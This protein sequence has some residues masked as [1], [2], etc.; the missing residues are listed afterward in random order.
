MPLARS[1]SSPGRLG[2]ALASLTAALL[3]CAAATP[4]ARVVDAAIIQRTAEGAQV[5]FTIQAEAPG[6]S[7]EI[8]LAR[9]HS[10][11]AV[12]GRQVHQGL[13]SAEAAIAPNGQATI[14]LPVAFSWSDV[15]L[16]AAPQAPLTLSYSLRARVQYVPTD[17]LGRALFATALRRPTVEVVDAGALAL[18]RPGVEG[19]EDVEKQNAAGRGQ[20][21]AAQGG[22][23]GAS[24]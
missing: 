2:L 21:P 23:G 24:R 16:G 6:A 8:R 15:G 4:H 22:D 12:E 19:V 14:L 20:Q 18:G 10:Q 7:E 9:V 17:V 1:V 11:F 13:R 5:L 3:G